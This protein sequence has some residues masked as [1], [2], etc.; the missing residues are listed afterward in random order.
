MAAPTSTD[1]QNLLNASGLPASAITAL[2]GQL[3]GAVNASIEAFQRETGRYPF[4]A[5][6]DDSTRLFD[7]PGDQS[8]SSTSPLRMGGEKVLELPFP[9]RSI[10]SIS[11]GL[12]PTNS[13]GKL[14]VAEEDYFLKPSGYDLKGKPIEWIEFRMSVL[15]GSNSVKI[16]GKA[17]SYTDW[18][19]DAFQAVLSMAAASLAPLLMTQVSGGFESWEEADVKEKFGTGQFEA[20]RSMFLGSDGK[21]PASVQR[22][23]Q[24]Y[25]F[26]RMGL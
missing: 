2:S 8:S 21:H 10:T 20:F 15:G 17:G 24:R 14:L 5:E 3:A 9:Y 4:I 12:S 23:I 18:P 25:R 1:L 19:A 16:V 22:V 13:G 6:A 11:T 26:V 7:P